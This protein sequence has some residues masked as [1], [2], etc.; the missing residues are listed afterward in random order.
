MDILF[1]G[2]F[3]ASQQKIIEFL[4]KSGDSVTRSEGNLEENKINFQNHEFLI[5]YGYRFIVKSK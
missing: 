2:P 3:R 1:L 4:I 5:S